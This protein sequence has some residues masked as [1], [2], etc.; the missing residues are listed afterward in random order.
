MNTNLKGYDNLTNLLTHLGF[1][2]FGPGHSARNGMDL[3]VTPERRAC[4]YDNRIWGK[5]DIEF[6]VMSYEQYPVYH[7]LPKLFGFKIVKSMET[8]Y[9]IY[10]E[11]FKSPDD[12]TEDVVKKLCK[13][14]ID[15]TLEF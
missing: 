10:T 12:I 6:T 2:P 13:K 5:T 15:I 4:F 9:G 3:K 14:A 11:F 8:R 1:V 7:K